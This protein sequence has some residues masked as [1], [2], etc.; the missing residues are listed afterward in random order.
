MINLRRYSSTE[1]TAQ[2][3]RDAGANP[4]AGS[5]FNDCGGTARGRG[6]AAPVIGWSALTSPRLPEE[7][8]AGIAPAGNQSCPQ[9]PIAP[10]RLAAP[11]FDALTA[12]REDLPPAGDEFGF[13]IC[14]PL[15]IAG[16]LFCWAAIWAV[17]I[18]LR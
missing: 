14:L 3:G 2:R 5:N 15:A 13:F 18:S 10:Q 12:S 4:A 11:E 6:P 17:V 7:H 8:R 1:E 9:S 16:G